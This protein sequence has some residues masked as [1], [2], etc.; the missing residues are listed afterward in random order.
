MIL[1]EYSDRGL[2]A[3]DSWLECIC[4][5]AIHVRFYSFIWRLC[6][7]TICVCVRSYLYNTSLCAC[8]FLVVKLLHN[9]F[10]KLVYHGTKWW[11][12]KQIIKNNQKLFVYIKCV[13][14]KLRSRIFSNVAAGF[15]FCC[16][17][18]L[19]WISGLRQ[20]NYP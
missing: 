20:Q 12:C 7:W 17:R 19:T 18:F 4:V 8:A 15:F 1:N 13:H 11:S 2:T 9:S 16:H 14:S 6:I 3:Y 10:Y 5:F